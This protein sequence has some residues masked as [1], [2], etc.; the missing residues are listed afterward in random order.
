MQ[1][2]NFGKTKV[3]SLPWIKL[4]ANEYFGIFSFA[5]LTAI[6]AQVTIPVK[7]IP[8]TLQS[9]MVVLAGAMLGAKKGAYSQILYL[10]SGAIGLPVF[11]ALP[12]SSF[13]ISRFFSATGGFL[14]AFP[15][16]AF[17]TGLLVEKYKNYFA[18]VVSM[19]VGELIILF[20]GTAF[21]YT[22]FIHNFYETLKVAAVIFSVW[23]VVKVFIAATIYFG[24]KK[25]K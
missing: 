1:I 3:L 16:A 19:F 5:F 23:T 2:K 8:F 15:F 10:V 22:F 24:F 17:I 12:E 11:A 9:M 18:V 13:G 25:G 14:L 7:P 21:L 20:S 4:V 6:A